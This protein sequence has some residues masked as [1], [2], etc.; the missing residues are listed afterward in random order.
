VSAATRRLSL[1][2][3]G[4]LATYWLPGVAPICP[5]VARAIG[6]RRRL[7][8]ANGVLLTFD[9][10]PHPRG[11]PLVL[12]LLASAGAPAVFFLVGEQVERR[13]GLAAEIAAAGHEIAL[14]CHRHRLLLRLTPRQIA[15]DLRRAVAAIGEATGRAPRLYRPPYGI[16]SSAALV[17]ARRHGWRPLLWSKDSRDWQRRATELSIA[18]RITSV[19]PG[20]VLLMH[21]ADHYSAPCSWQRTVAAL[22]RALPELESRGLTPTCCRD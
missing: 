22:A 3:G 9:D 4:G 16:F 20:D 19:G 10:G 11:T 8:S 1:L 12:E 6:I 15:D 14:H 2:T 13:P 5:P 21:D 17:L 7:S 18:N